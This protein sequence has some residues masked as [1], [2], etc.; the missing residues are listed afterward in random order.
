MPL[1]W[2]YDA[3]RVEAR[4]KAGQVRQERLAAARQLGT[5]SK[6]QW[7]ILHDLFGQ[8]VACGIPYEELRGGGATKDHI[9][10]ICVG[11]CDCIGNLQ[12][13]CRHCNSKGIGDDLREAT[14]P[15]WQ[16]IFLHR[17]GAFF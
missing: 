16:T 5:H 11:G 9:V 1:T 2:T 14:I 7:T 13:S 12:P 6:E 10:P 15:G 4:R 8:C 3:D 17:L